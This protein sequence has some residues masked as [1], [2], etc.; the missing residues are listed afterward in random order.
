MKR[1]LPMLLLC[2]TACGGDLSSPE[3]AVRAKFEQLDLPEHEERVDF[4][5]SR[6][7]WELD[8]LEIEMQWR[9]DPTAAQK[10]IDDGRKKLD[11]LKD[12]RGDRQDAALFVV[13]VGVHD[14]GTRTVS[15]KVHIKDA[16][17]DEGRGEWRL[18]DD[19]DAGRIQLTP[20][21]SDWKIKK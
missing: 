10:E 19:Y 20:A 5:I 16:K 6:L 2:L 17:Y 18:D 1:A 8:C 4:E 9:A 11:F 3:G 15:T 13:E 14:D 21:G 7:E 12:T